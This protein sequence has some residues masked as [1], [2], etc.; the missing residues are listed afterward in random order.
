LPPAVVVPFGSAFG[1]AGIAVSM[2]LAGV[3]A[4]AVAAAKGATSASAG[5]VATCG[6]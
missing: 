5:R 3:A 2:C 1:A 4:C 6:A